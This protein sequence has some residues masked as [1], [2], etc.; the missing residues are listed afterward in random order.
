MSRP[1]FDAALQVGT[2]GVL[3]AVEVTPGARSAAFPSGY[4]AW[5]K[6]IGVRVTAPPRDGLANADVCQ[7]V[8]DFFDVP[9]SG[10]TIAQGATTT[11][12]TLR[13]AGLTMEAA[14]ARLEAAT[15]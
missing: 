3:L 11:Q 6:R 15:W 8:A 5:R 14:R 2:D 1:D 10:V 7:T 12:K 9:A 4:N 13:L